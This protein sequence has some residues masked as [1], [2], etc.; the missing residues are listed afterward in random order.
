[1][2]A[3]P[4]AV[5]LRREQIVERDPREFRYGVD[6]IGFLYRDVK[7][8][9]AAAKAKGYQFKLEG[10]PLM[11]YGQPTVYLFAITFTP[12]GFQCEMV[13]QEGRLGARPIPAEFNR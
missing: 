5:G 8:A 1:V 7:A 13:Q 9:V 6:H 4:E 11:Y 12:D 2:L 3:E 10:A